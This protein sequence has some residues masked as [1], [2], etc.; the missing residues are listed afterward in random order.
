M[1]TYI[2]L[3]RGINVGEKNILPMKSLV[4][5][6]KDMGCEDIKT[7]IQSGNVVFRIKQGN[8]NNIAEEIFFKL[9][10]VTS[11]DIKHSINEKRFYALGKSKSERLLFLSFTIRNNLIRV[12]SARNMNRKER[13]IYEEKIEESTKI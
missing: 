1:N 10:L 13:K 6:L 5:I 11:D 12:I 4:E 3:F 8:P 7:Y 9:P 2:A